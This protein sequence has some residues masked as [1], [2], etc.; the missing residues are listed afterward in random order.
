MLA[1]PDTKKLKSYVYKL[2]AVL[3][4]DWAEMISHRGAEAEAG[5]ASGA[6]FTFR[7]L[8]AN[9]DSKGNSPQECC[10]DWLD[11][12]PKYSMPTA[13]GLATGPLGSIQKKCAHIDSGQTQ[14]FITGK[15]KPAR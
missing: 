5:R 12:L 2:S 1:P 8:V 4:Q 7:Q 9:T 13:F 14:G 10:L 11:S 15:Q 6:T 3:A